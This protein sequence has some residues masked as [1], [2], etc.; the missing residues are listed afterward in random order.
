MLW[1]LRYEQSASSSLS[2]Q[3]IPGS[4]LPS[5]RVLTVPTP[6]LDLA[7]DDGMLETVQEVWRQ[8][9]GPDAA[10]FMQFEDREGLGAEEDVEV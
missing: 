2:A 9:V 5:D 10:G 1:S 3:Q 7:F 6:S 8:I 4:V